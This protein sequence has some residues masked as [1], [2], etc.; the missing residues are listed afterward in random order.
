M[1]DQFIK[2]IKDKD[3]KIAVFGLG[4]VGV[5]TATIL[6]EAGFKVVGVDKNPT[7]VDAISKGLCNTVEPSLVELVKTTIKEGLLTV[8]INGLF[9]VKE[10]DIVLICVPTPVTRK[11][12]PDLSS[13]EEAC[14]TIAKGLSKGKLIILESTVPPNVT[15]GFVLPLLEAGGLKAG[16]DF[17][18]AYCPER[19]TPGE[20]LQEFIE[21]PR[22]IGGYTAESAELAAE[23]YR[24]VVKGRL[25]TT[26][27]A[28]AEIAKLAENTF[29]DVNIAFANEL[30]I[31]CQRMGVDSLKV[32]KLANTHPRVG[33]HMPGPGVG[34]PCL[35]KDPYLLLYQAKEKGS[36]SRVIEAARKVNEHMPKHMIELVTEALAIAEKKI[37][38]SRIVVLGTAYKG[39]VNDSR[40]SPARDIIEALK[41]VEA[42]IVAYDPYCT[43]TFGAQKT[44]SL[45]KAVSHADVLVIVTDHTPFKN[46]DL[47]RIRHLMNPNPI[48]IDG[49]RIVS[50]KKAFAEGFIYRGIGYGSTPLR[51]M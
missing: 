14:E 51:V 46:L 36:K 13:L 2:K 4:Y 1:K 22:L 40:S 7:A 21:N 25:L 37:A 10:S 42:K 35:S 20:T 15:N 33:I 5:P 44:E 45:D 49:R 38:G 18:V 39:D 31:I 41:E 34:G 29:R 6:A 27:L 9:A 24:T 47:Q 17:W 8:T 16:I 23:L 28:T 50:P 12:E 26:D 30:A 11:K 3:A 43:E 19:I 32:I 48:I